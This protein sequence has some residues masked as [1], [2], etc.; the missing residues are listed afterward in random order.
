MLLPFI[1]LLVIG[2][3]GYVVFA[4]LWIRYVFA[5]IGGLGII[6]LLA[7]WAGAIAEKKGRSYWGAFSLGLLTPIMIG[8]SSV[9]IVH[10]LGGHGCGGIVS[11]AVAMAI[12][13]FCYLVKK[14][15]ALIVGFLALAATNVLSPQHNTLKLTGPY[16]GQKP[17]ATTPETSAPGKGSPSADPRLFIMGGFKEKEAYAEVHSIHILDL[18]SGVN[19][20]WDREAPL[21][22]RL[23]GHVAAAAHGYIFVIGG[24]ERF[25]E[26]SRAVYSDDVFSTEVKG[27]HLGEW[28]RV[29]SLPHPLGYHAAVT[30]KDLIIISGGQTP[31]DRSTVYRAQVTEKGDL[32]GWKTAGDLPKPMRGHSSVMV[33]DRLFVLGGHND[34]TY[35][36]DV[37]SAPV[38]RDGR[39]G[40]WEFTTPLP[41]PVVHFGVVEHDGRI[42]VFGGQDERDDLHPEVYS[43]EAAGARLGDWRKEAPFPVPLSRMTVN[44]LDERIIVTGG[45]FGWAPP[46]HSAIFVSEIEKAGKLGN[47]RKIGDLPRQLAFHA[48]VICPEKRRQKMNP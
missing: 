34:Q 31:T 18:I 12:I 28:K 20:P 15:T 3:A 27:P 16:L 19:A 32:D 6:G 25:A 47:W 10:T 33:E 37:F 40:E 42:Y 45:G 1:G 48:A 22:E 14:R 44:I 26:G 39:L 23:Q 17:P 46:V 9:G 4:S 30:H 43:A 41:L 35:F 7:C 13:L 38:D 21:P 24:L 11:L 36:A 2:L 5:H 29:P 8:T